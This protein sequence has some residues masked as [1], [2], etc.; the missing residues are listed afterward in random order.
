MHLQLQTGA[1]F[2]TDDIPYDFLPH[3]KLKVNIYHSATAEFFSPSD[4]PEARSK[5]REIIR[6]TGS[7]TWRNKNSRYDTV[8]VE[9]DPEQ[10]GMQGMHVAR[11]FLFF[12]FVLESISYPC[13]LI[14]WFEK[15][16]DM[17]DEDTGMWIVE[18]EFLD[19]GDPHLS[20]I[21]IDSLVRAAHLIPVFGD[22]TMVPE[23]HELNS[24]E[25]LDNFIQFYVNKFVDYH[26]HEIAQ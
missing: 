15:V 18:P 5:Y 11:V 7:R 23:F 3:I 10:P 9:T 13:A 20:V 2:S 17:P 22:S 25:T 6:C 12:N 16:D 26:A 4:P 24:L 14:H 21:H 8:F 1:K 19:N